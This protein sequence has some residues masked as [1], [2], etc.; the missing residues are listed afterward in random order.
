[1]LLKGAGSK[2][3]SRVAGN[4]RISVPV[5]PLGTRCMSRIVFWSW[6]EF[7]TGSMDSHHQNKGEYCGI[8][9]IAMR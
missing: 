3:K 1:V 2:G 4:N 7:N 8:R 9:I 5:S 6:S